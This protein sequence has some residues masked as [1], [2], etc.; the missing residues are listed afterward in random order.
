MFRLLISAAAL[1]SA[2]P[3][4]AQSQDERVNQLII[5]GDDKCPV[6]QDNEITVCAR[7]AE[8]ERYRIPEGLRESSSPSNDA[9]NNRVIAYE[10][11]GKTGTL[12]CSPVGPGGSTGCLSKIINTAYAEKRDNS[13]VRFSELIAAERARRLATLDQ[14]AADTQVRVEQAEK[15]YEARK[16]AEQDAETAVKPAGN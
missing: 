2:V 3:A 13:D 15:E 11:I 10:A 5:Y 1:I 12:S 4:L 8:Q 16:R 14:D 6:S 9:W 7:K